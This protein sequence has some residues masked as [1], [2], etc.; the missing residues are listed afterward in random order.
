MTTE[1][2]YSP[3]DLKRGTC[4]CCGETSSEIVKGEDLCADCLEEI[5]FLELCTEA[6]YEMIPHM[7]EKD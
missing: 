2:T 1:T 3:S 5:K 7:H 6:E 4:K